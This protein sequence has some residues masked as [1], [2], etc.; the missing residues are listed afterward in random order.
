MNKGYLLLIIAVVFFSSCHNKELLDPPYGDRSV[1]VVSDRDYA[2]FVLASFSEAEVFIHIVMYSM[3]YYPDDST[4]GVSQLLNELIKAKERG[5]DVRVLL[6]RSEYNSSLNEQNE[7][8]CVYLESNGID[9]QFDSPTITTHGKLVIIDNRE[10]FIGSANW[11]K[12]AIEENNEVNVKINEEGIVEELES[13]FQNL[14]Y[15]GQRT[16][17]ESKEYAGGS[18]EKVGG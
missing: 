5:V 3:K 15:Q 12:S 16:G 14:W 1:I 7:F 8:T 2:S 11:S 17:K 13:Y 10:A 9:V 6:E 4:N 18:R